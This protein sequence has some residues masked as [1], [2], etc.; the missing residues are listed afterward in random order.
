ML[1]H[2]N[3]LFDLRLL[4]VLLLYYYYSKVLDKCKYYILCIFLYLARE[5]N[6][7]ARARKRAE[8]SRASSFS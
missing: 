1:A 8:P 3:I 5:L 2:M 4:N 6:E 7:L